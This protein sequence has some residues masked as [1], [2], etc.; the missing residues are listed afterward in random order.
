MLF[1]DETLPNLIKSKH[2]TKEENKEQKE[3]TH[4]WVRQ[5]KPDVRTRANET[6]E[7]GFGCTQHENQ[8]L[9][10]WM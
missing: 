1:I 3:R 7:H 9:L 10:Q 8:H 2:S 5:Q 4:N 6:E